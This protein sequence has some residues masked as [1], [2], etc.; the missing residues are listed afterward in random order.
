M[1]CNNNKNRC[2]F[3]FGKTDKT[4]LTLSFIILTNTLVYII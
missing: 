1:D 3:I 2:L 4:W